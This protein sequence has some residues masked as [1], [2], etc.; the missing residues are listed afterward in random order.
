MEKETA[1]ADLHGLYQSIYNKDKGEHFLKYRGGKVL[2]EAHEKA[3]AWL[4]EKGVSLEDCLDFG[5]GEADFLGNMPKGSRRIGID[6][7]E[8]ALANARAK[9]PGLELISGAEPAL[10]PFTSA[11]DVIFSFGTLEHT[12]DP[13]AVLKNLLAGVKPGGYLVVSC[14]SFL[15]VRGV[16]WMTLVLLWDVPMS[17]SDRHFLTLRDFQDMAAEAG[18]RIE[19]AFSAELPTAQGADFGRDMRK[20]LTNA[21]RDAKMDNSRVEK[22]VQWF[23]RNLADF[24]SGGLSGAETVYILKKP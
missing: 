19:D 7:S 10:S 21:L 11:M 1:P 12:D 16:I 2:S 18:A 22:A 14:P 4:A 8:N 9:Y 13:K 6:Y 23:E 5:C 24:P 3:L 17:L 20:R 15:N